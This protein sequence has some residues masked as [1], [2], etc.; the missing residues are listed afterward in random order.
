MSLRSYPLSPPVRFSIS[1]T[2]RTWQLRGEKLFLHH[3]T[4]TFNYR[5]SI[6]QRLY[7]AL[8]QPRIRAIEIQ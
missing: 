5:R 7:I 2:W 1:L 8:P 6:G 4:M 3:F